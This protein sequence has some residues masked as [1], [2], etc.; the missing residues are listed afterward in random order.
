MELSK[1]NMEKFLKSHSEIARTKPNIE[2]S[3]KYNS[4]YQYTSDIFDSVIL[5]LRSDDD[6]E[7]NIQSD[8][9]VVTPLDGGA[10]LHITEVANISKYCISDSPITVPHKWFVNNMVE[11]QSLPHE[12]PLDVVSHIIEKTE[13]SDEEVGSIPNWDSV[14]KSFKLIKKFVY[15][16][17]KKNVAFAITILRESKDDYKTMNDSAVSFASVQYEFE[18]IN[19][20]DDVGN[21]NDPLQIMQ[22]CVQMIQLIT[23]QLNPITKQQQ[24]DVLAE[25]N[26][27]L[28]TVVKWRRDE[29]VPF[30]F[31][32]KPITLEA[33]NLIEPSAESYGIESIYSGYA[34]T[35]KADG[36]RMLLYVAK[37]GVAYL[38]NNILEVYDTG[39]HV[40][41]ESARQ[42]LL[43]GEFINMK[44]RKDKSNFHLFAGFDIYFMGGKQTIHLPLF[45]TGTGSSSSI[46]DK[47]S[48][49]EALVQMCDKKLWS[50]RSNTR[51][52]NIEIRHK[53]HIA[54]EGDTMKDTCRA[55]LNNTKKLPYDIDGLIFTPSYLSVFGY[56]PGKEAKIS[57]N[58]RWN[59]ELKW[60]PP[61]QN[62]ID[63]LVEKGNI[64]KDPITQ[65]RYVEYKLYTGY[66]AIQWEPI[67]VFEGIR[68]RY[69]KGYNDMRKQTVD[70]YK[71]KLFRPVNSPPEISIAH[72]P[73]S[74][75]D[76]GL[77]VCEDGS[78]I[79]NRCIVEFTY[80]KMAELAAQGTSSNRNKSPRPLS[81]NWI[82]LRVR[83]D[84]TRMLQK[85]KNISKTLNDLSVAMNIWRTINTP[86]TREMIMGIQPV[87]Q[88]SL[89]ISLEERLLG[90][91]DIYY[92]RSIPREHRL[93]VHMLNFHNHGIKKRLYA[94][95]KREALLEL[96]CGMAGDMPRW[97]ES[98]YNF[99]LGV[100]LVRD[101]I[102]NSREGAYAIMLKQSKA[103]NTIIEGV[104]T[105]IF[106]DVLF[107]I[108]DCSLPL[109]NGKAAEG[110][111][112]E[113]RSILISLF[114]SSHT[115]R[116]SPIW[117]QNK[118]EL[119]PPQLT[120]KLN[121]L[122]TTVSAMFSLHYFFKTENTL[123]GF[124]NNV[125]SNL[126]KGG[127]F[128]CTFMDGDLVHSMLS[129]SATGIVDG[130]KLE[131]NVPVWAVIKRYDEFTE[132]NYYG[133]VIDV[134]IE[135]TNRLIPEYLVN[136]E[137]LI[138][139]A[140]AYDLTL[141][142]TALFSEDF[143][144]LRAAVPDDVS[145]RSRL[146][147][148]IL[149]LANDPIQTQFSFLNRWCCFRKNQ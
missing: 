141:E 79:E 136:F 4:D 115:G 46:A 92:A 5:H 78:V 25:Y 118:K 90:A 77:G 111:D 20:K 120:G 142:K 144:V 38:I 28:N 53:E 59:K 110:I 94:M 146:D 100:D 10:Q 62:S 17:K 31:A 56:Y 71:E 75:Y 119:I 137:T 81:R 23:G 49:Y 18:L 134:F 76:N 107:V 129:R 121:N 61:S 29:T 16:N 106:P 133:K 124:L 114:K 15:T 24:T 102:T 33:H 95:G 117:K 6:Y 85:S 80:D 26:E 72:V 113:S 91:D 83:D 64:I 97:R 27:L 37:S 36:E 73:I 108:G 2:W 125:A 65:K 54:A 48:R 30:F 35:D 40:T 22:N 12:L 52:S 87:L 13:L 69:E 67:S 58:V 126:R 147:L 123:N 143:E 70:L 68:L 50:T 57:D 39:L 41:S 32:P 47:K 96:A 99:V 43:D 130:R 34:V 14:Q 93:S 148:D 149:E 105:T 9:L 8:T 98:G 139:K 21:Y 101:N 3:F 89:P 104:Q 122:F 19:I 127:V 44:I 66:N 7:E 1:E 42:T 74:E 63:F 135:N 55:I 11:S 138:T 88:S 86:V 109:H 112:D 116:Y 103:V 128:I 45:S 145:K 60:K 84:K 82:A 140:A 51:Q 131:A 132:G